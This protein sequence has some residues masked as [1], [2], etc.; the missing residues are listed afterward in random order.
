MTLVCK[1]LYELL[2]ILSLVLYS[3]SA[4]AIEG[5]AEHFL[6]GPSG[7]DLQYACANKTKYLLCDY[8]LRGF[9]DG[10]MFQE[11]KD[12]CKRPSAGDYIKD[13][14]KIDLCEA[15][16]SPSFVYGQMFMIASTFDKVCVPDNVTFVAERLIVMKYLAYH[17]KNLL[18]PAVYLTYLA[19]SQAFSC[20]KA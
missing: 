12:V 8:L 20:P 15:N 16:Y 17:Q 14:L 10:I 9:I 18:M 7:G 3:I 6:M 2:T 11:D 13:H 5:N 4:S 19:L 1:H